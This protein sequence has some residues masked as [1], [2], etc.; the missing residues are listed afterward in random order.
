MS[1]LPSFLAQPFERYLTPCERTHIIL[2]AM[3]VMTETSVFDKTVAKHILKVA[4]GDPDFWLTDVSGL[5]LD[6]PALQPCQALLL[7]PS[8][9][10]IP[11]VSGT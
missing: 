11:G 5:W 8:L 3:E 4:M 7:S 9:P 6:C 10:P 2:A 1:L